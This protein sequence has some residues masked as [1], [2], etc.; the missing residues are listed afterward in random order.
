MVEPKKAL[1]HKDN[2]KFKKCGNKSK[3]CTI[4]KLAIKQKNMPSPH[5]SLTTF[6]PFFYPLSPNLK[7]KIINVT[8]SVHHKQRMAIIR[9]KSIQAIELLTGSAVMLAVPTPDS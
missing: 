5:L 6:A 8:L 4:K 2:E 7:T 9:Y 1:Y 3:M